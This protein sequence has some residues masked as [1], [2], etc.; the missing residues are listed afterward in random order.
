MPS[1]RD[2]HEHEH[3]EGSEPARNATER[4][5]ALQLDPKCYYQ[6]VGLGI[7]GA[8]SCPVHVQGRPNSG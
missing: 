5:R 4:R 2:I 1:K 8:G 3:H 7:L 6:G